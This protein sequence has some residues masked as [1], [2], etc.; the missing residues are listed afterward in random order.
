MLA[1][2]LKLSIL[3]SGG[4]MIATFVFVAIMLH[5]I[6]TMSNLLSHLEQAFRMESE[7]RNTQ[8][9]AMLKQNKLRMSNL[10]E[11]NRRQEALLAIPLVRT[12]GGKNTK[13]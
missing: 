4:F 6:G 5:S 9:V 11:H 7:L 1:A 10:M 8:Y 13:G 3:F 2:D 12:Q